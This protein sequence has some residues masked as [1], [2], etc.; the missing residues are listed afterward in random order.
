MHAMKKT[1]PKSYFKSFIVLNT[2]LFACGAILTVTGLSLL[3][4]D[5]GT[6]YADSYALL[7]ELNRSLVDK[8]LFLFSLTL[9]LSIAAIIVIAILY[10]HRVAG[11]LYR[12][13]MQARRIASGDLAE[14]V[15]LR[16]TDVLHAVADD[17]NDL[18]GRYRVLLVELKTK[19]RELE[20][21]MDD[22]ESRKISER[23]DELNGLL[24]QIKS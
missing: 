14:P 9:L 6:S 19:T 15:H 16:K 11:P 13:G 8:T 4:G 21:A 7:A 10:S 12:L 24:N 2:V 23:I 17:L 3:L 1:L 20:S 22:P 18:S 5:R